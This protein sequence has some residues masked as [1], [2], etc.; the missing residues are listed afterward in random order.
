MTN[1]EVLAYDIVASIPQ[2]IN[3]HDASKAWRSEPE[4][5]KWPSGTD[6]IDDRSSHPHDLSQ[7]LDCYT[8]MFPL[9]IAGWSIAAPRN[10][11]F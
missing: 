9:Y 8:L 3:C 6:M 4:E 10:V 11:K 2:Y 5:P 7:S 1:I